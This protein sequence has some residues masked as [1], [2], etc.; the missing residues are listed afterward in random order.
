MTEAQTPTR[1][2]RYRHFHD[3]TGQ[4]IAT[5]VSEPNPDGTFAVAITRC[6][7]SDKPMRQR[8]RELATERLDLWQAHRGRNPN[9][10]TLND[11]ELSR[12]RRE[13][14]KRFT[15]DCDHDYLRSL[16]KANPFKYRNCPYGRA[17]TESRI[18]AT[19]H[20]S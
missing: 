16:V 10:T 15:F 13:N 7:R 19:R 11:D 9:K 14:A 2:L 3:N 8:G 17:S 5:I 4:L 20:S 12:V 18:V 1:N 6:N